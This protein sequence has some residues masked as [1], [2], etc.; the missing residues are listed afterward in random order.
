VQ[1]SHV[2]VTL[3]R[4]S[5][6]EPPYRKGERVRIISPGQNKTVRG[7][8]RTF[9]ATVL[10]D[11]RANSV[12]ILRDGNKHPDR[13]ATLFLERIRADVAITAVTVGLPPSK[14]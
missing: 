13:Y 8:P 7:R 4:P 14:T 12:K 2:H 10:E 9:T 3:R 6:D 5:P 1:D 11:Q